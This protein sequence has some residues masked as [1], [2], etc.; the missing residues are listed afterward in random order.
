MI[1]LGTAW[2]PPRHWLVVD[3][4]GLMETARDESCP[5][6]QLREPVTPGDNML[7]SPDEKIFNI[8][9]LQNPGAGNGDLPG[10]FCLARCG[11]P[12]PTGWS[13]CHGANAL[14]ELSLWPT[15][16]FRR[17]RGGRGLIPGLGSPP[18]IYD[19]NNTGTETEIARVYTAS[20]GME[21]P[22]SL[23]GCCLIKRSHAKRV[24]PLAGFEV[25]PRQ[26]RIRCHPR[27]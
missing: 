22:T 20:Q 21:I 16:R 5:S 24:T 2:K 9:R 4:P 1:P 18:Y 23:A 19:L 3:W 12:N 27:A 8:G 26:G 7:S 17:A 6:C 14:G 10:R 15:S 11:N 13:L 25:P